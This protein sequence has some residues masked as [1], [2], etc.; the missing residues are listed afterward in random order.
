MLGHLHGRRQGGLGGV[1]QVVDG[2]FFLYAVHHFSLGFDGKSIYND[3]KHL[4]DMLD[5]FT[6]VD[7]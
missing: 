6:D 1:H 2:F 5:T 7:K 3:F 4:G